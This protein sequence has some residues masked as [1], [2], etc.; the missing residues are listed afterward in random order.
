ML[1][2][3]MAAEDW[4]GKELL[5]VEDRSPRSE[6]IRDVVDGFARSNPTVDARFVR[7]E[8]T[9]GYDANLRSTIA[10][11]R[12][13]FCLLMADDDLMVEGTLA[14]V[15]AVLQSHPD[16]GIVH[17]SWISV[18]KDTGQE[19]QR[20]VYFPDDRIFPPG[21]PSAITL[22]R[23]VSFVSGLVLRRDAACTYANDRFDGTLLYQL[24]LVGNIAL[25]R[26]SYAM[27]EFTAIG[28]ISRTVSHFFGSSPAER[29]RFQPGSRTR[30]ESLTFMRGML[31]IARHIEA[32]RHVPMAKHVLRD[33]SNYSYP[34]LGFQA[35]SRMNLLRFAFDLYQL[36]YRGIYF[37]LYTLGFLVL[38]GAGMD[39]AVALLK[40]WLGRTP[41]LG[42]IYEGAAART[43]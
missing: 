14:K 22:F 12:G 6:E 27:S 28:R 16:L 19:L 8:T 38:G 26:P 34:V 23:R 25:D 1:L 2:E 32:T 41:R 18:D 35:T 3:S 13:T 29:T 40:R 30:H 20:H 24:Y 9:L 36:G 37:T 15:D 4:S 31:D 33:M 10:L 43:H 5:V 17:R 11:A 39:R 21:P 7:N 42:G